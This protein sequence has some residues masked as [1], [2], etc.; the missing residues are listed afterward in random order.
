MT[1]NRGEPWSALPMWQP[2]FV[3]KADWFA[4]HLHDQRRMWAQ[5]RD[6]LLRSPRESRFAKLMEILSVCREETICLKKSL[7]KRFGLEAL[8]REFGKSER[9]D[10]ATLAAAGQRVKNATGPLAVAAGLGCRVLRPAHARF[11][12]RK[13]WDRANHEPIF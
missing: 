12:R 9:P 1:S 6:L 3:G 13:G 2:T 8:L 11:R 4:R 10:S 7:H 5:D